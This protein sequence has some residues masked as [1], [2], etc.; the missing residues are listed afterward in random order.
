LAKG[1]EVV[2][3]QPDKPVVFLSM[4]VSD[5]NYGQV[6]HVYEYARQMSLD[7]MNINHLWMQTEEMVRSHNFLFPD[8]PADRITWQVNPENIEVEKLAHSLARIRAK[9]RGSQFIL[10]ETPYLDHE[11]LAVWYQKPEKPVKWHSTRCAWMRMKV[12]PDGKVK[13]CRKWHVGNISE[14]HA[15]V[16]W[17]NEQYRR[18]RRHLLT[19]GTLSICARCCYLANR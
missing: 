1:L 18:F 6:D 7:G 12:W 10:A 17:N 14:Q 13:P 5:L 4:A 2:L 11:E 15:M 3:G 9:N 8:Y 19:D 16:I